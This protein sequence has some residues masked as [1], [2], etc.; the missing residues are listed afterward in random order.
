MTMKENAISSASPSTGFISPPASAAR[1]R[2]LPD[3]PVA[4][5]TALRLREP[6]DRGADNRADADPARAGFLLVPTPLPLL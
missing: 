6:C 5:G 4:H 2:D 1:R 3:L